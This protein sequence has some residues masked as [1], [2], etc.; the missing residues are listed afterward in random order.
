L[1]EEEYLAG[2]VSLGSAA[3]KL[4]VTVKMGV[5]HLQIQKQLAVQSKNAT[6]PSGIRPFEWTG[7]N[8]DGLARNLKSNDLIS[9]LERAGWVKTIEAGGGKSGPATILKNSNTGMTVRVHATPSNGHPYFRARNAG[10]NYLDT[11]GVFPHWA[12]T[13]EMRPLTHFYFR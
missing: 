13:Q 7:K 10:G 1:I 3:L 12:T 5:T 2:A 9:G 4:V 11:N 6:A 8:F